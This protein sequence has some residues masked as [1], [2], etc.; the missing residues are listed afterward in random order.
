MDKS[1]LRIVFFGTPDFAVASLQ[2][3]VAAGYQ[4]V[5]VVTAPDKASGRGLKIQ[6]PPVK[7]AAQSLG[8]PVLQPEKLKSPDFIETLKS[9]HAD[10]QI[11]I[12]FRMLPEI[13]WNMPKMGTFNLHASLLPAYRGAAPINHVIIN[14]ETETGVSTFFLQHAIDTGNILLQEKVKIDSNDNAGSL[15]DKLMEIGSKLVVK[16]LDAIL[17]NTTQAIPQP[18]GEFPEAPKIFT[19]TCFI[20]WHQPALIVHNLVRGL[21]PYPAAFTEFKGKKLKVFETKLTDEKSENSG[22]IQADE[23]GRL[24]AHCSDFKLELLSVQPEGKKRMS[25]KDFLNGLR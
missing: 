4:V 7:I 20:N 8:I 25:A 2:A 16:T 12:A 23:Q 1:S 9:F 5:A 15:H 10:L 3:V 6:S 17:S 22:I 14:G 18:Q 19:E 13:V 21:S 24:M 11:V